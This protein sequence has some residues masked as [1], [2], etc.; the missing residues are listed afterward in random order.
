[1]RRGADAV[2]YGLQG[3]IIIIIV[4]SSWNQGT[5]DGSST[6]HTYDGAGR[7]SCPCYE[8]AGFKHRIGLER[9]EHDMF[10]GFKRLCWHNHL[11]VKLLHC[12]IPHT[13]FVL[14]VFKARGISPFKGLND[15]LSYPATGVVCCSAFTMPRSRL[16]CRFAVLTVLVLHATCLETQNWSSKLVRVDYKHAIPR[17]G[18]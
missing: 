4:N 12:W 7:C 11:L 15:V 3:L 1:V 8:V 18:R 13:A 6:V 10:S 14:A 17:L 16:A 2:R 9:S 5:I